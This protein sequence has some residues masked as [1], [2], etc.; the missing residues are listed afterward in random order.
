M[1][2][3][4][5]PFENTVGKEEIVH[6]EQFILFPQCFLLSQKI[7]SQFVKI[8]DIVSL[9]AAE[10]LELKIGMRG[11]KVISLPNYIYL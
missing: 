9:F 4:Q 2:Q 11:K 3:Q 8:F 7:V 5:T 6:H 10:L 1:H